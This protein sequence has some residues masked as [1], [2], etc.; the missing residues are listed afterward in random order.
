[1]DLRQ[2]MENGGGPAC[3]RL[4]IVLSEAEFLRSNPAVYLDEALHLKLTDWIKKHYRD[5]LSFEDL[6]DPELLQECRSA[7]DELSR[8]LGLGSV[9]RFQRDA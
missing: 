8:M 3:L 1:V 4:R 9:Y 2:S 5:R 7:L 6:S